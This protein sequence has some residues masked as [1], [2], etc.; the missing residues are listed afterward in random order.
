MWQKRFEN[1]FAKY[2]EFYQNENELE[3]EE[4]ECLQPTPD[5]PFMN[6]QYDDYIKNPNREAISK[7]NNYKNPN[8]EKLIEEKF[9]Y[10]LYKDVSDIFSKN[11]SQ[12]QF[13]T[14]PVTTIQNDQKSFAN[15]LYKTPP[16]CKENNGNQ[17]VA[18]NYYNLK[19]NSNF[20]N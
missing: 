14:T 6:V 2:Y 15:W 13:Y 5:N 16:T 9:N 19:Q 1:S 4:K 7:L 12:R 10:N 11:N 8:L 17:C 18:N 3:N 20:K